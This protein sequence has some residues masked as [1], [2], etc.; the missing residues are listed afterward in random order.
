MSENSTEENG[1]MP[2]LSVLLPVCT[3]IQVDIFMNILKATIGRSKQ[4]KRPELYEQ[5]ESAFKAGMTG[6]EFVVDL[7]DI[8]ENWESKTTTSQHEIQ[9]KML[10]LWAAKNF[11]SIGKKFFGRNYQAPQRNGVK[12]NENL[13]IDADEVD[14]FIFKKMKIRIAEL[15]VAPSTVKKLKH[16]VEVPEYVGRSNESEYSKTTKTFE[17][18]ANFVEDCWSALKAGKFPTNDTSVVSILLISF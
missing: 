12:V 10:G 15:Y 9:T 18:D 1:T 14:A 3:E 16:F 6:K 2:A 8:S 17:V 5:L 7:A 11:P 4:T 13:K